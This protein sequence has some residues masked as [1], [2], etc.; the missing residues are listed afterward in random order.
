MTIGDL[1]LIVLLAVAP[2]V[3]ARVAMPTAVL[4]GLDPYI[5]FSLSFVASSAPTIPLI[6]GL[7][8]LEKTIIPKI[9][10]ISKIY[11][12]ILERARRKAHRISQYRIVYLGL[13]LYVAIPFPLT[14]V[15]TGSLIA[16]ILDLDKKKS[17]ISIVL[18]N[19]VACIIILSTIIALIKIL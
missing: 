12:I 8:W 9:G 4:V 6:Y 11:K 7:T 13:A 1:L 5:A 19:L 3:E 15:W 18:G 16:Y 14:G 2:G 10:F 17:I